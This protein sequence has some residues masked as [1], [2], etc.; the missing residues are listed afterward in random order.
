MHEL[1]ILSCD[2]FETHLVDFLQSGLFD[3]AQIE[4]IIE[5]YMVEKDAM[6]ARVEARSFLSRCIWDHRTSETELL[7][8]AEQFRTTARFL[9]P[10]VV[11]DLQLSLSKMA[12]GE[13]LGDAL[14][15][16][17]LEAFKANPPAKVDESNTFNKPL[18][19]KIKACFAEIKAND[20]TRMTVVDA[21]LYVVEK[22]GWGPVQEAVMQR[23]TAADFEAAIRGIED[24]DDLGRFMRQM[25]DMRLN[26]EVFSKHFGAASER[27]M[28]ACRAIVSDASSPRLANLIRWLVEGLAIAHELSEPDGPAAPAQHPPHAPA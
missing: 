8:I 13:A 3:S 28:E 21:C 7:A 18:H 5:R 23:A 12:G 2:E 1:G 20:Q 15:E 16:G 22:Q 9:D 17:W 26:Q 24:L 6:A 11:T 14:I 10:Y 19:E 27:F 4:T 25:L